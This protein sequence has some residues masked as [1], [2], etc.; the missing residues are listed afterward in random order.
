MTKI[1]RDETSNTDYNYLDDTGYLLI[2]ITCC[3]VNKFYILSTK[4]ICG[5]HMILTAT[6]AASLSLQRPRYNPRPVHVEFVADKSANGTSFSP[7]TSILPHQYFH[8][9]PILT[10]H[11]SITESQYNG[12]QFL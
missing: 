10:L 9:S 4:F 12:K 2:F 8:H 11:S 7:R 6:L 3:N 5:M 1:I